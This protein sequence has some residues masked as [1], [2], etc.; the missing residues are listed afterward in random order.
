[1]TLSAAIRPKQAA[2]RRISWSTSDSAIAQVKDGLVTAK[3]VGTAQIT[4][5]AG[6]KP[7]PVPLPCCKTRFQNYGLSQMF[8]QINGI[9]KA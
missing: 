1:M 4:A 9:M 7:T 2:H 5:R 8:Q 6:S 3:S